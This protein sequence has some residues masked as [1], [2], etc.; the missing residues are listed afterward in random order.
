[1]GYYV[2]SIAGQWEVLSK[3][4]AIDKLIDDPGSPP[5]LKTKLQRV[6]QIR[7]FASSELDLP[8]NGSY[9]SFTRLDRE[10]VVWAVFATPAFDVEPLNWCFPFVGCVG[11]RGYFSEQRARAFAAELADAGYDVYVGGVGAYSTL[12]WFD[13]PV[14]DT[15]LN[16][17]A[18]RLANVIFHELAHQQLYV[19]GDTVFN[20]SFASAVGDI[21]L[22]RWL[23]ARPELWGRHAREQPYKEDFV[24]LVLDIREALSSAYATDDPH[25]KQ[26]QKDA[27]FARMRDR[28]RRLRATWDDYDGYDAWMSGELNNAKLAAVAS[29]NQLVP[30]FHAL[31]GRLE[32]DLS[33][34]YRTASALGELS[35]ESRHGCLE[36]L[37]NGQPAMSSCPW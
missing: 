16:W 1:M 2:H 9:T 22:K 26:R 3:R 34:F 11:Y 14:L 10:F 36:S 13:D 6:R 4:R 37:V 35:P 17:P 19:A 29:Y 23:S 31:L 24:A 8:D 15:M 30:A 27:L 21:G 20:E 18:T 32:G 12:G 5:E 25:E 33:A 28:Y 7:A